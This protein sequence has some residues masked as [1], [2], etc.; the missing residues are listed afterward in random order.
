MDEEDADSDWSDE[1]PKPTTVIAEED[2]EVEVDGVG[3]GADEEAELAEVS[4]AAHSSLPRSD[5]MSLLSL[6]HY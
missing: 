1:A 6:L 5:P 2:G 4:R 3:E